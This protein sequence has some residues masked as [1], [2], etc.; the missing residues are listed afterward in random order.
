MPLRPPST[1]ETVG[2]PHNGGVSEEMNTS[3][4]LEMKA[5]P[6][7]PSHPGEYVVY[8]WMGSGCSPK[9]RL[10]NPLSNPR[11]SAPWR[12]PAVPQREGW[13]LPT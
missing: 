3:L 1:H 9:W 13:E 10:V 4:F 6:D 2:L 5:G 11:P 12:H 8:R 7:S